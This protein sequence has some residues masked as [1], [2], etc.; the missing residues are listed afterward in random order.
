[1]EADRIRGFDLEKDSLLR[2]NVYKSGKKDTY[3][4]VVSQ[5][6]INTDGT[7]VG[8]LFKELY[9]GYTLDLN[10]IDKKIESQ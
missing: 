6:H 10:G 1:M 7:S 9:V 2:I 3:S 5:P 8:V 4:M